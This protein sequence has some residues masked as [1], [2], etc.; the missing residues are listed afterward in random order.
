MRLF[1]STR[2]SSPP[3]EEVFLSARASLFAPSR[4][5]AKQLAR[6]RCLDRC[7]D[8]RAN[9]TYQEQMMRESSPS[10]AGLGKRLVRIAASGALENRPA[11]GWMAHGHA[12][13][14]GALGGGRADGGPTAFLATDP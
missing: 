5:R 8:S 3:V 1:L 2:R 9:R 6:R 11:E 10:L 7:P 14:H 12:R 13:H 4:L